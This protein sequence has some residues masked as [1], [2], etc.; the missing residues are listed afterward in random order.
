[1]GFVFGDLV[2]ESILREG[3]TDLTNPAN[4]D[5]RLAVVYAQLKDSFLSTEYGQTEIDRYK[6]F[7]TDNKIDIVHNWRMV[8]DRL[9]CIYI[10][11]VSS[12]EDT[13]KSFINDYTGDVDTLGGGVITERKEEN[14]MSVQDTVQVGIHVADPAGPTALRW[15]YATVLYFLVSRKQDM[16]DRGMELSTWQTTDFNRLNEFLPENV[17]SRYI[18]LNFLNYFSF[19]KR[20]PELIAD[21]IDMHGGPD[22]S[23]AGEEQGGVKIESGKDPEYEKSSTYTIDEA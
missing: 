6:T 16:V 4:I 18:S 19:T 14:T 8:A 3:L 10:Q 22:A 20:E 7:L 1:V 15:L 9:P 5:D 2:I 13:S 11:N 23:D 17:F 21:S 12:M